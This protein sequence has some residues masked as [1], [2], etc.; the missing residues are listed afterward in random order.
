MYIFRPKLPRRLSTQSGHPLALNRQED[1]LAPL[2]ACR[3]RLLVASSL[4][5]SNCMLSL[6]RG[7]HAPQRI[8]ADAMQLSKNS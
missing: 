8:A 4:L 1:W 2:Q 5:M 6:R 3:Y 7:A